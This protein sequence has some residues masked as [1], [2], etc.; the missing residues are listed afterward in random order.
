MTRIALLCSMPDANVPTC[1]S[2]SYRIE[3]AGAQGG[4]GDSIPGRGARIAADVFLEAGEDLSVLVGQQG[5][6]NAATSGAG[7]EIATAHPTS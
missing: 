3:A 5:E 2:A 6:G 4:V 7:G 1:P